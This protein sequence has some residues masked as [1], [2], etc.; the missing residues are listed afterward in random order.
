MRMVQEERVEDN[1]LWI[2]GWAGQAV[3]SWW[4]ELNGRVRRR[5][6]QGAEESGRRN[7]KERSRW[8]L[9]MADARKSRRRGWRKKK[10][11]SFILE[12]Q[13]LWDISRLFSY[14]VF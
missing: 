13:H 3:R 5:A 8:E 7:R 14:L 11:T 4:V 1:V 6:V 2:G 12:S 10:M 9:R